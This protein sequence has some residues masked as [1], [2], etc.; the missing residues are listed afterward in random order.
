MLFDVLES[1]PNRLRGNPQAAGNLLDRVTRSPQHDD[2]ASSGVGQRNC[3]LP[4]RRT[5]VRPVEF[6]TTEELAA[7]PRGTG[8]WYP[9]TAN[10]RVIERGISAEVE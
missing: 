4:A 7:R 10:Q 2:A 6:E 8:S 3:R 5:H 9:G 1:T